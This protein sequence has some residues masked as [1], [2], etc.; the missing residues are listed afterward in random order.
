[1]FQFKFKPTVVIIKAKLHMSTLRSIADLTR[2]ALSTSSR[3]NLRRVSPG[4][5]HDFQKYAQDRGRN[6]PESVFPD[7]PQVVL[8]FLADISNLNAV[9]AFLAGV[10]AGET[11]ETNRP[12]L[13]ALDTLNGYV[14]GLDMLFS[15]NGHNGKF[16]VNAECNIA[17][18][19][20]VRS[21]EICLSLFRRR[22][23]AT[24]ARTG[25][26]DPRQANPLGF[27]EL[28]GLYGSIKGR[29]DV[30]DI[31]FYAV[32]LIGVNILLRFDEIVKLRMESV[33]F[34]QCSRKIQVLLQEICKNTT[35]TRDYCIESWGGRISG[36]MKLDACFHLMRWIL[37]R[38]DR[39]GY[40]FCHVD[41]SKRIFHERPVEK[42]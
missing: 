39:P 2:V 32:A 15:D 22:Y 1:M 14:Q 8:N 28:L 18:G 30:H 6:E 35:Y 38:G 21:D 36:S 13:M 7:T 25:A 23:R 33:S 11:E 10:E 26:T 42:K 27:E 20:P 24:L 5:F 3:D 40:L 4:G 17:R 31:E 34:F 19:N 12:K 41:S 9:E 37:V 16:S 29:H